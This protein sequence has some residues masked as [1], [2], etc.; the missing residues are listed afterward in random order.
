VGRIV[1]NGHS[2]SEDASWLVSPVIAAAVF[3]VLAPAAAARF[4]SLRGGGAE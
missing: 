1:V 3:A 4:L 2:W